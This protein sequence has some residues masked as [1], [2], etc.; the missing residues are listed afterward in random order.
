[1]KK[2]FLFLAFALFV[3]T[4]SVSAQCSGSTSART[5]AAAVTPVVEKSAEE[6]SKCNTPCTG[7]ASA[8][9]AA[10]CTGSANASTE[11]SKPCTGTASATAPCSGSTSASQPAPGATPDAGAARTSNC[12]SRCGGTR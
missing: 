1:M 11:E 4:G 3:A 12:A 9:E 2:V 10:P 8:A 5:S 7:T 6:A